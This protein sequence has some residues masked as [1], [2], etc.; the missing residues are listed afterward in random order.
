MN[1]LFMIRHIH[2]TAAQEREFH[3]MLAKRIQHFLWIPML[4]IQLFRYTI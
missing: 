4:L 1:P 3:E 2:L